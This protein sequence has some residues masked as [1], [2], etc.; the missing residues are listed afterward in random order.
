MAGV[1]E[2]QVTKFQAT[3]GILYEKRALAE[4]ASIAFG[5]KAQLNVTMISADERQQMVNFLYAHREAVIT[6]L[7]GMDE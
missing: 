7:K 5:L 6:V 2:V 3:D 1:K 4:R